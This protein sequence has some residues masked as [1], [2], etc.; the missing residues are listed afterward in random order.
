MKDNHIAHQ[1]IRRSYAQHPELFFIGMGQGYKLNGKTRKS[2]KLGLRMR[3]IEVQGVTYQLRPCFVLPY[4]R[5]TIEEV[6]HPLFLLRFGEPFWAPQAIEDIYEIR[7][8]YRSRPEKYAE[9]LTDKI[10]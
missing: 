6:K 4:R 1:T 10:F 7:E 8:Y 9:Q 5:A 3:C 2:N